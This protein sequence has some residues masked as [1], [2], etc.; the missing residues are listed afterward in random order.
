MQ[1]ARQRRCS[2]ENWDLTVL[3]CKPA[4]KPHAG[5]TSLLQGSV[6]WSLL[7]AHCLEQA[8]AGTGATC[9]LPPSTRTA[10]SDTASDQR[11]LF[12]MLSQ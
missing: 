6:D 9:W 8:Q 10:V 11:F 1:G 5:R 4:I 3:A 2:R 7:S 12:A